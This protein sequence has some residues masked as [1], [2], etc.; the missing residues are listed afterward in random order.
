MRKRKD[1]KTKSLIIPLNPTENIYYTNVKQS[2]DTLDSNTIKLCIPVLSVNRAH[3]A[4]RNR[5]V[6]SGDFHK[7]V[8]ETVPCCIAQ[9]ELYEPERIATILDKPLKL[10]INIHHLMFKNG[11]RRRIDWDNPIKTAQ[12]VIQNSINMYLVGPDSKEKMF[13]DTWI[14]YVQVNRIW[15]THDSLPEHRI[16]FY[17]SPA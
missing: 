3:A 5:I 12:D 9:L 2:I 17:L 11:N 8:F 15:E 13:D 4:V 14:D 16:E 1:T 6:P 10:I 7:Y